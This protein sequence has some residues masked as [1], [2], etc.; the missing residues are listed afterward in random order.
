MTGRQAEDINSKKCVQKEYQ[1][2]EA[3]KYLCLEMT[4]GNGTEA[5]IQEKIERG[6]RCRI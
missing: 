5:E 1:R 6:N 3:F 2:V 4:E